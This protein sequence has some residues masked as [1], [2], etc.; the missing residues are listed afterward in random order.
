[1]LVFLPT[2][3]QGANLLL[4]VTSTNKSFLLICENHT[5]TADI[6][7]STY[8]LT[9]YGK[10]WRYRQQP[11]I[12]VPVESQGLRGRK[13][14]QPTHIPMPHEGE[15]IKSIFRWKEKLF[16]VKELWRLLPF[17]KSLGLK[18]VLFSYHNNKFSFGTLSPQVERRVR[19]EKRKF[20]SL[21]SR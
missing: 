14:K 11:T 15:R 4:G 9:T 2:L 19:R 20:L 16:P 13:Q 3:S 8:L 1:M 7:D 17:K 6:N 21:K 18:V 5:E 10:H 12:S